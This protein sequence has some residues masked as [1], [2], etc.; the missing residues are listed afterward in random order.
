MDVGWLGDPIETAAAFAAAGTGISGT[1][2]PKV[3]V[4]AAGGAPLGASA[5]QPKID[6]RPKPTHRK[7]VTAT[8]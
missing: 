4:S 3:T 1:G 5:A 8:A 6:A 2:L 7:M